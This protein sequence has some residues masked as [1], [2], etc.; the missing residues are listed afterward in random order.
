MSN[1]LERRCC[2]DQQ[3][4]VGINGTFKTVTGLLIGYARVSTTDRDLTAQR[5]ALAA[6][7]VP[8]ERTFTG[9]RLTGHGPCWGKR[10]PAGK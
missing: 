9:L 1:H 7:G 3:N 5:N 8:S 6:L 10:W 4:P 2:F